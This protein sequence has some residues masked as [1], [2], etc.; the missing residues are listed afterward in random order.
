VLPTSTSTNLSRSANTPAVALSFSASNVAA[1]AV[2]VTPIANPIAEASTPFN[3]AQASIFDISVVNITGQV[4]VCVDG[5]PDVKLWHYTNG[6]WVDIT[7]SHTSTQTCG[8]TSSF[9]PFA[10]GPVVPVAT[11]PVVTPPV[12]TP[13]V[14][15]PSAQ[16]AAAAVERES[17]KQ[18]AR[19]EI[20]SKI[21]NPKNLTVDSFVKAGIPGVTAG[22]I[23]ALQTELLALPESARADITQVL[24]VVRK[25]EV[26]GN[27][28][29]D[30]IKNIPSSQFVE[31]G[32]IPAA[33]K[34][35]VALVSAIRKLPAS[36][37]GSYAE[38]KA[39]IDAETVKIKARSERTAAI[40]AR[41]K[42][43]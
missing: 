24:K 18:V 23:A 8:L 13:P 36:A 15:T 32:L 6:A 12:V 7:T 43:R 28:A 20:M 29:S 5:G 11:P 16:A 27:I 26:V 37:R 3:V 35:K 38:I 41:N 1:P 22:N 21:N 19:T 40:A 31:I 17:E 14:V 2:T 25:F 34:N 33:S 10:T 9:S 42:A 39:A 4:T 30:S